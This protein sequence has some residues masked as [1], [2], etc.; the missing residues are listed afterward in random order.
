MKKIS[1][2]FLT[3]I[4]AISACKKDEGDDN[5][6]N[7]Q[8]ALGWLATDDISKVP[9][10]TNFSFGNGTLPKKFDIT[11]KFPPIGDQGQYGTC[12][13]WA[14]AY[15]MKSALSAITKGLTAADLQ[16]SSNQFSPKDLF[17]AMP[18]KGANCNGSNFEVALQ[19][20]QE[21]GVA[22]MATVPYTNLGDCSSTPQSSWTQEAGG[23]KIKYWRKI[24]ASTQSI[25]E[26]ISNNVPV[27][28]GAKLADNFMAWNSD[29]VLSSHSSFQNVG[30]HAYH[31]LIVAGYDDAKG[32]NGAFR[33]INSWGENWGDNGYIWVDYNF[34]INT[35]AKIGNDS[36][37]FIAANQ[38]GEVTPPDND[39]G[40][41]SNGVDLASWITG[42]EST[43]FNTGDPTS[44]NLYFNIYNVGKTAALATSNWSV[45][46]IYYNAYDANDYGVLFYDEFNTSVPKNT[47]ECPTN[48]HCVVNIDIPSGGDFATTA[49]GTDFLYRSY[50]MP[51]ITGDYYLVMLTDGE[52][53]FEEADEQDNI[54]YTTTDPIYFEDGYGLKG[55][56]KTHFSFK[57]DLK[58]GP[59]ITKFT[60]TNKT[61]F[62]NAYTSE[63]IKGFFKKEIRSERFKSKLVASGKKIGMVMNKY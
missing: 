13:A 35:F 29:E 47:F 49:F 27:V 53:V 48:N 31:A 1:F 34:F 28:F 25:K 46:Y 43:Y 63:E 62:K 60:D 7:T 10:S 22:T 38:D 54:F 11:D 33:V 17:W 19:S 6:T 12:V 16:S 44:R 52:D 58:F 21:R 51:E 15:N 57:N 50:K 23:H 2:I 36:P 56:P 39:P 42:D 24:E 40:P 3:L 8:Y 18:E 5:P 20:M 26:N 4:L 37:L 14:C 45:Y 59:S 61:K 41:K 55:G 9:S 32:P 30:Q